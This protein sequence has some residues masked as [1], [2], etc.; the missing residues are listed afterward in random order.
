MTDMKASPFDSGS[1]D[2]DRPARPVHPV[3][4]HMDAATF[5]RLGDATLRWITNYLD[6]AETLPVAST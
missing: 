3:H 1:S 4:P 2:P 6:R 5:E